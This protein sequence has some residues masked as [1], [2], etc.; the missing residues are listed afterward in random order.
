MPIC[1]ILFLIICLS[2]TVRTVVSQ[3]CH[4]IN[5]KSCFVKSSPDI[6]PKVL[7]MI[8]VFIYVVTSRPLPITITVIIYLHDSNCSAK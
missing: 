3:N 1:Q 8:V 4:P 7:M 6:L 2:C 5:R